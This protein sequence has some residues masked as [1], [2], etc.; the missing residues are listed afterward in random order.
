[1]AAVL[2]QALH[3]LKAYR[4]DKRWDALRELQRWWYGL[5]ARGWLAALGINQPA[6]CEALVGQ[7]ILPPREEVEAVA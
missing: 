6:A 2:D 5:D 7:G 3:D 1:V 4:R